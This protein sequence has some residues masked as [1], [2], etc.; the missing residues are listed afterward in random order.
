MISFT[1]HFFIMLTEV[2]LRQPSLK[3]CGGLW[4]GVDHIAF[5]VSNV[6]KSLNFYHNVVGMRK[7]KRPTEGRYQSYKVFDCNKLTSAPYGKDVDGN[8]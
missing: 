4:K 1:F 5:C 2:L 7:A 8:K 3:S 6:G